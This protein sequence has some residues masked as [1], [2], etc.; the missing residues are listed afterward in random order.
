MSRRISELDEAE[1]GRLQDAVTKAENALYFSGNAPSDQIGK[2]RRE[3]QNSKQQMGQIEVAWQQK[4]REAEAKEHEQQMMFSTLV[5]NETALNPQERQQYGDFLK[6][7]FFTKSDFNNLA[8]FYSHSWDKLTEGGKE[9]MSHRVWEGV[10]H[11]EYKFDDLP[12]VVK[13]K[14][15]GRLDQLLTQSATVPK[16]LEPI[17]ENDRRQFV[18]AYEAGEKKRS[19]EVLGRP[20]F[21]QNAG[22][23]TATDTVAVDV[24]AGMDS[25]KEKIKSNEAPKE[26][27]GAKTAPASTS[28]ATLDLDPKLLDSLRDAQATP[29]SAP[30]EVPAPPGGS[31][32]V[33]GG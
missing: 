21:I 6:E 24:T 7:K 25:L 3:I 12:D 14:E 5:A 13:E 19:Y 16:D 23:E 32:L 8:H 30:K 17:P 11:G 31:G 18:Q 1:L 15:A 9:Q 20:S 2:L 4:D 26:S 28:L 27:Q 10:R 22:R 33:K 29:G